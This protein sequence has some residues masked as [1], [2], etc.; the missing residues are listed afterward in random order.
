MQNFKIPF[1]KVQT[2]ARQ[3]RAVDVWGMITLRGGSGVWEGM[4]NGFQGTNAVLSF[5]LKAAYKRSFFF[6][7]LSL[8]H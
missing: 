3:I 4:G 7:F 8:W 6:S 5:D 1:H 2:Q